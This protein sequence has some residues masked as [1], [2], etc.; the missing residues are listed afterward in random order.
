MMLCA[1]NIGAALLLPQCN[2]L[3]DTV[4][5]ILVV[6]GYAKLENI[7]S[8]ANI[9]MISDMIRFQS[10]PQPTPRPRITS[11]MLNCLSE[12][13]TISIVVRPDHVA[14]WFHCGR[15]VAY[16]KSA[17]CFSQP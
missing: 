10:A 4:C 11:K 13:V 14:Q 3:N 17:I 15:K 1:M 6:P 12:E 7:Q 16:Q 2:S 9:H 5:Y 8:I